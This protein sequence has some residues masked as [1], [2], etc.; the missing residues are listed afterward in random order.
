MRVI[1][2][3]ARGRLLST[4]RNLRV[5]PTSDR[6]KEALFSILTSR[7]GNLAG[8][9]VLDIFAGTGSLGI[10]ALSRGAALA[11]FVDNHHESVEIIKKNLTLLG[12]SDQAR[13]VTLDALT[14]LILLTKKEKPFQLIFLDPPYSA[15]LTEKVLDH[16]GSSALVDQD[17][18]VVA[19]FSV[20]ESI[21]SSFGKLHESDRRV[22]GDTALSI[23]ETT[24]RGIVC[25]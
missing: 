5:R 19:E 2:G 17:T 21:P 25:P 11:T 22:Y 12:F 20:K 6:V 16:L 18:L 3:I 8:V 4:P 15:G 10:E 23:L 24:D 9:R 14:A 7:L 13:I 1:G